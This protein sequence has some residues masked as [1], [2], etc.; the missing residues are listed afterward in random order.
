MP[1][2][3]A[4][5]A[6]I[7]EW[8]TERMTDL[9]VSVDS[10]SAR[11]KDLRSA[12]GKL[13]EKRY[14]RPKSELT[15][16]IG[17]RTV[18]LFDSEVKKVAE[19]LRSALDVSEKH[20]RTAGEELELDEFGYRSVHLVA[21]FRGRTM[22]NYSRLG[23]PWVEVQ[24]RSLLQHAWAAIGHDHLYKSALSFPDL[25][26]RRFYAIAGGLELFDHEFDI[27]RAR[28][29]ESHREWLDSFKLRKRLADKLDIT[30]VSAIFEYLF[31]GSCWTGLP[32]GRPQLPAVE[33]ALVKCLRRAG[34]ETPR[35]VETVVA[36]KSYQTRLAT[37]ASAIGTSPSAVSNFA[38]SVLVVA[39]ERSS[40]LLHEYEELVAD[41]RLREAVLL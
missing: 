22:Q 2:R 9:G 11:A 17:A 25:L 41:P 18:L 5:A 14:K 23:R 24:V 28:R 38:K 37:Y 39:E 4:A 40:L 16:M 36:R 21:K 15:D 19:Y 27:I 34:V 12:R 7:A 3:I 32:D 20:S 29:E 13:R 6:E 33:I 26:K 10:V 31:S 8:I 35:R 30:A 1:V